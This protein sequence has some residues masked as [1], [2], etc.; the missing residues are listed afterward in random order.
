MSTHAPEQFDCPAGQQMPPWHEAPAAHWMPQAPQWAGSLDVFTQFGAPGEPQSV[1]HW[2]ALHAQAP[3]VQVEWFMHRLPQLPQ[4]A[5]SR[6]R[7]TQGGLPP[8]SVA[9]PLQTQLPVVQTASASRTKAPAQRS[10]QVPQFWGSRARSVQTPGGD[11]QVVGS[12]AGQAQAPDVQ[13]APEGHLRPQAPQFAASFPF[14]STQT[15][16]QHVVLAPQT[17][18]QA[19]QFDGSLP[20]SRHLSPHLMFG[21]RQES[22]RGAQPTTRARERATRA[23]ARFTL[24]MIPRP[25][26]PVHDPRRPRVRQCRPR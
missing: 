20:P 16:A 2:P 9:P 18:P 26:A 1:G 23:R 21:G 13:V 15:L 4:L 25:G 24:S 19:P 7:S 14:T 22:F 3:L 11:P 5:P 10:P 8:Q 17:L 6:W 12:A